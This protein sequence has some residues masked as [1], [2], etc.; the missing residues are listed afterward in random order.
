MGGAEG[1]PAGLEQGE[2]GGRGAKRPRRGDR[3]RGIGL[4]PKSCGKPWMCLK[5]V[6]AGGNST[7]QAHDQLCI[8]RRHHSGGRLEMDQSGQ[9]WAQREPSVVVQTGD[10]GHGEAVHEYFL[11]TYS[12][13]GTFQ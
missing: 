2:G 4:Q 5:P 3:V 11:S 13:P 9:R 8:L 7:G 1:K 12:V 10:G 6:H